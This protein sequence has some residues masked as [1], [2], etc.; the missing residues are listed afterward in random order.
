MNTKIALCLAG[1]IITPAYGMK[2]IAKPLATLLNKRTYRCVDGS[3]RSLF[4]KFLVN[5]E[6]HDPFVNDNFYKWHNAQ[7]IRR[8]ELL[9]TIETFNDHQQ[10]DLLYLAHQSKLKLITDHIDLTQFFTNKEEKLLTDVHQFSNTTKLGPDFIIRIDNFALAETG[11]FLVTRDINTI[12]CPKEKPKITYGVKGLPHHFSVK[13]FEKLKLAYLKTDYKNE[14]GFSTPDT[15][16]KDGIRITNSYHGNL[17]YANGESCRYSYRRAYRV[18]DNK[19][20]PIFEGEVSDELEYTGMS[21][22]S[23]HA[24]FSKN[25]HY[26]ALQT[27]PTEILIYSIPRC[28]IIQSILNSHFC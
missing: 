14:K 18:Y 17:Y 3:V 12:L 16:N 6:N 5:E 19:P 11:P 13:N 10:K 7:I 21:D 22:F 28:K 26:I 23:G 1:F 15:R 24:A 9:A 8:A 25:G 2:K 27:T 4:S 20:I